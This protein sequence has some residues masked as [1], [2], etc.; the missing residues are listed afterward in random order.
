[1][2]CLS[3]PDTAICREALEL[4]GRAPSVHN[5][6]P[7]KWRIQPGGIDLFA[8]AHRHPPA[9]DPLAR[10]L[11]VS[12]GAALHHAVVAFHVLGW[13]VEIHRHPN[14]ADA[15]HLAR[16][17]LFPRPVTDR[18]IGWAA[19]IRLRQ[20]DRRRFPERPLPAGALRAIAAAAAEHGA[21]ARIVPEILLPELAAP[22]R[23][24]ADRHRLDSA[25][26]AELTAWSGRTGADA[27]VP[28]RNVPPARAAD[29]M[30]VRAF[31]E[32]ALRE[33]T[34][35]PDAAHWLVVCTSHDDTVAQ[36]RAGE[37]LSAMV[38]EAT[39]LG[40]ASSI[41]SEPLGMTD[42]RDRIRGSFLHEVAHPQVMLRVGA[43]PTAADPL[44]MTPRRSVT[45]TVEGI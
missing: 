8:D 16:L 3:G 18:D 31:A 29:E 20:S 35:G 19:A 9:T 5:T 45:D 30:P 22:M 13:G 43:M 1:M 34:D 36:L 24:A 26:Q 7:W 10:A 42:L 17:T 2:E 25:Y 37:A 21:A 41:Q 44:P 23:E 27:G 6:Q 39:H 4:A 40:L 11:L 32:P 33:F 12:C 15:D 28:A 14:P 38:L